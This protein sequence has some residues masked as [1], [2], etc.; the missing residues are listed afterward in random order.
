[1]IRHASILIV[2]DEANVVDSIRELFRLDYRIL[3]TT[4]P[5]EAMMILA[6]EPVDVVMTDQRIS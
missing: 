4:S 3:G 6:R 5:G 1:M 2:D